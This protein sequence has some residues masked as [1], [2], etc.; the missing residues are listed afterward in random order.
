MTYLYNSV[1]ILCT[2]SIL[3]FVY[4]EFFASTK[5]K[6]WVNRKFVFVGLF[7]NDKYVSLRT[8][9]EFEQKLRGISRVVVVCEYVE[10]PTKK[11]AQAVIDNFS[12]G[13]KYQFFIA[14]ENIENQ[15][16]QEYYDWFEALYNVSTQL[17]SAN[18]NTSNFNRLFSVRTIMTRWHGSPY[19]FH[20]SDI[21][22]EEVVAA[23]RG[24]D[25]RTGISRYYERIGLQEAM[26]IIS[27]CSIA[28][29]DFREALP[30]DVTAD[31]QNVLYLKK[32]A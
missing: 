10:R 7:G 13:I 24:L 9:A 1:I 12:E 17:Q 3:I 28:S 11:L 22:D 15:T 19:V 8:F 14:S 5:V 23:Y 25:L 2:F 32:R 21:G 20:V 27:L 26:T 6:A 18:K 29:K 31:G 30:V 16:L 4:L